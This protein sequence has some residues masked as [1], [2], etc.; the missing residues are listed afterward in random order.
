VSVTFADTA[1]ATLFAGRVQQKFNLAPGEYTVVVSGTTA[2]VTFLGPSGSSLAT[3]LI[4]AP[5]SERAAWGVTGMAPVLPPGT[6]TPGQ[7]AAAADDGGLTDTE[8]RLLYI[9]VPIAGL[10][11]LIG[12]VAAVLLK[13][14]AAQEPV[15]HFHDWVSW[16]NRQREAA[17]EE[18]MLPRSS[19]P[20]PARPAPPPSSAATPSNPRVQAALDDPAL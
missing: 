18:P 17:N 6:P 9:L 1:D 19:D 10:L 5:A 20:S 4:N 3:A 8:K 2:Q 16:E 13:V 11:L 14:R 15:L 12:I 7:G